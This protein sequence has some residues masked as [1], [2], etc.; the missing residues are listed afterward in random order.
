MEV[1]LDA[2]FLAA[3]L[4]HIGRIRYLLIPS[5]LGRF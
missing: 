1:A 5:I 4:D 3:D 2:V